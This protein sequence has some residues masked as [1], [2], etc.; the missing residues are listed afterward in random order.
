MPTLS[1]AQRLAVRDS[2]TAVAASRLLVL[3]AGVGAVL[4]R[5]S[6][7]AQDPSGLTAPF[8]AQWAND[9]AAPFARFDSVWFLTIAEDGYFTDSLPAFFPLYPLLVKVVGY[10]TVEPLIAGVLVS[11]V[12]MFAALVVVHRL[13]ALEL[14]E[15]LARP[16]VLL[17]AFAPMAFYLSAVYSESLFLALSVGSFY[18]GRRRRW[19]WAG[20]LGALAALTRSA[21]VVMV[22]PLLLLYLFGPDR[23][24]DGPR[25]RPDILWIALVPLGLVA[26][27]AYL[28]L[29]RDDVFAMFGAQDAWGREFVAPFAGIWEGIAAPFT[30]DRNN[31]WELG[32][33]VFAAIAV[34][35]CFRRLPAAYGAYALVAL[36]IPLS[37][38][39]DDY[40]LTSLS[41]FIAVLFPLWMWVALWTTE[42]RLFRPVLA[43]SALGLALYAGQFATWRFVS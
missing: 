38:P 34:V 39:V 9:L 24:E 28:G 16:T 17:V 6:F 5:G 15:E 11:L 41:R 4:I 26:F 7:P 19:V 12:A 40:P 43:L 42:R 23:D 14:G 22:V 3:L 20:A 21:G 32:W 37:Y 10:V 18:M 29:E 2:L 25:V 30:G 8:G 36:A 35:G 33:L 1:E 31:F 13:V 27:G